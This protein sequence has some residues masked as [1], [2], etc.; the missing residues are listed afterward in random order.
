MDEISII[1]EKPHSPHV[2]MIQTDP[3]DPHFCNI[4][5]N[6]KRDG[7]PVCSHY[8]LTADAPTW[9]G[10]YENDGFTIITDK[11]GCNNQTFGVGM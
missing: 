11:N 6:K 10:Y 2:I 1:M 3:E 4:S 8:I 9:R 5:I 7:S